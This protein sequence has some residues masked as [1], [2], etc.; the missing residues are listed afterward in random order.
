M[1]IPFWKMHGAGNDFIL[2]NAMHQPLAPSL[3]VITAWCR[4]RTGIGAEGLI[5]LHP[6]RT[7]GHFLMQFF[8]P[9][10]QEAEMC[11]N[12]AR[13]AARLAC[14]LQVAPPD[15]TIETAAGILR[16]EVLPGD[17]G[18][19]LHLPEP[20]D[21]SRDQPLE[22]AGHPPLHYAFANTGV[23]HAV[24]ECEDLDR[25][26]VD[27]L[28][29]RIRHHVRFAPRGT[30]VNFITVTA[31]DS[32]RIRTYERG[33]EA[34]T[35]ACGTGVAAAAVTAVLRGRVVSPVTV[36]TAGG[37]RLLVA[38]DVLDGVPGRIILTGP[39]VHTFTG[40][41]DYSGNEVPAP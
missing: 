10:G 34:E 37:D 23:P 24:I 4:R 15:M 1:R 2:I 9:D 20:R 33:V 17:G 16:A 41:L 19:R 38:V 31:P 27:A 36:C 8:N 5:L 40:T 6:P 29:A 21:C 25:V 7:S 12:G 35:L 11:G 13:C 18:V 32:L 28:G 3:P 26:D 39:A 14:E 30:N 22:L